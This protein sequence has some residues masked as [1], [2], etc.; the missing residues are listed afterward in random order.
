MKFR[1]AFLLLINPFS[2]ALAQDNKEG[3]NIFKS[4]WSPAKNYNKAVYLKHVVKENDTTY[5]CRYY[6]LKGPMIKQETYRDESNKIPNGLFLWYNNEGKLD[7]MGQMYNGKKD[8]EWK[9]YYG[10]TDPRTIS[11]YDKGVFISSTDY[12]IKMIDSNTVKERAKLISQHKDSS[13]KIITIVQVPAQF[14]GGVKG[15]QNYLMH[16]MKTPERFIKLAGRNGSTAIDIITFEIDKEGNTR[17]IMLLKSSEWSV[18][19]EAI[20]VVRESPQWKPAVQNGR[21]VIY[22]HRQ[23]LTFIASPY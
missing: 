16:N 6:T 10:G 3:F 1:F 11:K 8:G 13:K 2:F 17:N 19:M 18:D 14:E 9:Y 7:T 20:R 15:W 5:V 22:K 23:T 4:D 21:N 12:K